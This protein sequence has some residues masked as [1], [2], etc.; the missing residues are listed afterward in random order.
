MSAPI[1]IL[2]VRQ[3]ADPLE[4]D[5]FLCTLVRELASVF[6]RMVGDAEASTFIS[7]AGQAGG[8]AGCRVVA[9]LCQA[10]EAMGAEGRGYLAG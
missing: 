6:D 10:Q 3:A 4:R 5:P 9:H 8:A 7:I 2:P 1:L